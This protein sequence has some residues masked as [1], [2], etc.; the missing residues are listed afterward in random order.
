MADIRVGLCMYYES[1]SQARQRQRLADSINILLCKRVI[2]PRD[3]KPAVI[4]FA[5]K[6]GAYMMD[7]EMPFLKRNDLCCDLDARPRRPD[8]L[9]RPEHAFGCKPRNLMT[10]SWRHGVFQAETFHLFR[11]EC[12]HI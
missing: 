4:C 12:A 6:P 8:A 5:G 9:G 2:V 10:E 1:L 11:T 7:A 3:C